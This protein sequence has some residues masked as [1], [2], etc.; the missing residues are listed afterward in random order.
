[1]DFFIENKKELTKLAV[2]IVLVLLV[3]FIIN[4][5]FFSLVR[6]NGE[7]MQPALTDKDIIIVDKTIKEEEFERF[8]IVAFKYV[9]D[10]NDIYLKRII[11]MPNETIEIIDNIIYID[12]EKLNE[13]YGAFSNPSDSPDLMEYFED[14]P[15]TTLGNNEYFVI[16]DNR[17]VSDDS[18]SFG[19]VEREL[20]VGKATFRIWNFEGIG[21]LEYQ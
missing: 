14:Y 16:G 10:N 12:G 7:S 13:F 11:G 21:S 19:P 5:F 8:D 17:Y 6:V 1:M 4:K 3:I 2:Y 18:R 9:Y 15:K 20:I